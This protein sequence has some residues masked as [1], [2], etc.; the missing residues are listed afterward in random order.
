M[1]HCESREGH[2][3]VEKKCDKLPL[4]IY[5]FNFSCYCRGQTPVQD[6]WDILTRPTAWFS[7][8][9]NL[10]APTPFLGQWVAAE[11]SALSTDIAAECWRMVYGAQDR[12]RSWATYA[13]RQL[14]IL[15]FWVLGFRV[16]WFPEQLTLEKADVEHVH[17][18]RECSTSSELSSPPCGRRH[19]VV[20]IFAAC[21][22]LK[23]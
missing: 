1:C 9:P 21:A 20:F 3:G 15:S 10:V 6:H 5:F 19:Q 7:N 17:W 16:L 22:S 14:P 4:F 11:A 13:C 18:G 23:V 8:K 2:R 12:Q